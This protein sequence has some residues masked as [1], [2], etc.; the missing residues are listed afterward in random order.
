MVPKN[1]KLASHCILI[2]GVSLAPYKCYS[3]LWFSETD[4]HVVIKPSLHSTINL[5]NLRGRQMEVPLS[6]FKK[7]YVL[8]VWLR[9]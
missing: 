2:C 9:D 1:C 7:I 5:P 3:T 6:E 4:L 8:P